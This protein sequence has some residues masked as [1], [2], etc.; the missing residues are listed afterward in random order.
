MLYCCLLENYCLVKSMKKNTT[1]YNVTRLLFVQYIVVTFIM[2]WFY[3]GGNR[4]APEL[5]YFVLDQNYLSDLGRSVSFSSSDNPSYIF[6]SLTLGLVGIGILLFFLH[7]QST[8]ISK[9]K[10]L[11]TVSA[12]VSTIGYIG[13]ACYPVDIDLATH[14]SYGRLAFLSFFITTIITHVLL[15]KQ[16]HSTANKL[17]YILNLMLFCYLILIFFGPSST[18]GVWA[19]QLKTIAQKITVYSQI[20]LCMLILRNIYTKPQFTQ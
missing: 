20:L 9:A 2:M 4:Y 11:I 1:L 5:K 14:V 15:D 16:W 8:M 17:F 19:L 18:L 12:I 13:I 7:I 6:Y 10:Y 3:D